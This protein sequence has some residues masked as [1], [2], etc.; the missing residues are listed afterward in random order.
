MQNTA[1]PEKEISAIMRVEGG[2]ADEGL[3]D[4]YDA[5]TMLYGLARSLNIVGHAFANDEEVRSRANNA[6]G[7][8]TL[9]NSSRKGCFEEQI[10]IRFSNNVATRMGQSVI[11]NNF[12][13]YLQYSF[14]AA[15]GTTYEATTSHLRKIISKDAEYQYIIGDALESALLDLHKPVSRGP[16]VKIIFSRPRVGDIFEYVSL[17]EEKT[18]KFTLTGNVTRYNV[19]SDF[20][21]LYSDEQKRV[22]SFKLA[23]PNDAGMVV[24]SMQDHVKGDSGKLY[25]TVTEV[26]NSQ[27]EVKRYIVHNVSNRE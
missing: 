14:H 2:I 23:N 9:I 10:D 22:I 13:D 18:Q 26:I 25:F 12:W 16:D 27:G 17:R 15:V 8:Q 20:G 6:R 19:L 5:S 7:V 3:I 1:K 24:Q 21:R 11:G 4:I